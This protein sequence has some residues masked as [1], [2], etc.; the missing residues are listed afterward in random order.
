MTQPCH[1]DTTLNQQC[2]DSKHKDR[3]KRSR[4]QLHTKQTPAAAIPQHNT[5]PLRQHHYCKQ[6]T[7]PHFPTHNKHTN[8]RAEEERTQHEMGGPDPKTGTPQH[9]PPPP[10]NT[11]TE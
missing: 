2:C 9:T 7:P 8:T 3:E 6:H 4:T 10:F 1:K 5:T 11:A